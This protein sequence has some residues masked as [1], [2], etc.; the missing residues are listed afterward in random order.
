MSDKIGPRLWFDFNAEEAV[1]VYLRTYGNGRILRTLTKIDIAA[2]RRA[3][4]G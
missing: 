2:V 3:F 4:D 1:A